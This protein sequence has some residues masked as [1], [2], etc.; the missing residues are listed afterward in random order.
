MKQAL[1]FLVA[2][3]VAIV[4]LFAVRAYAFTIYT[5]PADLA[6]VLKKGDRVLVN[7]MARDSFSRGDLVV[8]Q[9]Q[10][11]HVGRIVNLPGDTV[12]LQ[13]ATYVVPSVCCMRCGCDDC[14]FYIV[15]LGAENMVIH[16][17]E[18]MGR[19]SKLFYLPW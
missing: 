12:V 9:R 14:R 10:G 17:H 11:A 7:R 15:S 3:C 8:F 13:G 6:S 4:I 1:K 16:T 19:A 18:L 2:L 5:V